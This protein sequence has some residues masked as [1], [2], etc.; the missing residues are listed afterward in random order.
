LA[1]QLVRR[2]ELGPGP[3]SQGRD[4]RLALATLRGGRPDTLG[5]SATGSSGFATLTSF[6]HLLAEATVPLRLLALDPPY[7]SSIFHRE[8]A[9]GGGRTYVAFNLTYPIRIHGNDG[10]LQDSLRVP[11]PSWRQARIPTPGEFPDRDDA[12]REYL[13]SF[14]VISGL[15]VI[16]DS[17]LVVAHGQLKDDPAGPYRV[18]PTFVDVYA[19]GRRIATDLPSPGTL[20]AYSTSRLFFLRGGDG[21]AGAELVE[22]E[23]NPRVR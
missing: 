14:T 1:A 11:P 17:V 19:A 22:Y 12:W 8:A 6:G 16:G 21:V 10:H 7:W 15:A 23:W 5:T 2:P 3:V 4:S 20:V 9:S 13:Q 18:H